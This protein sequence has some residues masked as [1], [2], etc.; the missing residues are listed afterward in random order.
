M[1][2]RGASFQILQLLGTGQFRP[3][4]SVALALEYEEVLARDALNGDLRP[5]D[6]G[7]FLDYL[8]S[9]SVL[10]GSVAVLRPRLR[11]P[12]DEFVLELAAQRSAV[13]ITYN[14][15]DFSGASDLGVFVM[16]PAELLEVL[17][18]HQ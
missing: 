17:R 7:V 16:T 8:F 18:R 13:I 15:R 5:A 6:L 9:L 1:S 3:H 2:R 4:I 10:V 11:D 12:D 14:K